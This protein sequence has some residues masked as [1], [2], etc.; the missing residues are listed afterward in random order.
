MIGP[1]F[2]EDSQ[3]ITSH[4]RMPVCSSVGGGMDLLVV[5]GFIECE[6]SLILYIR[7]GKC[8][9]V[10]SCR[11]LDIDEPFYDTKLVRPSWLVSR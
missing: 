8:C 3:K 6:D 10:E 2:S 5:E 4:I 9:D 11:I 7:I 1:Q